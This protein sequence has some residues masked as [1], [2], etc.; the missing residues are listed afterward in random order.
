MRIRPIGVD[1]RRWGGKF[2]CEPASKGPGEKVKEADK[3]SLKEETTS[4]KEETT[5]HLL[6]LA[7][8]LPLPLGAVQDDQ[9][10]TDR[11]QGSSL[12]VITSQLL[13]HLCTISLPS[14]AQVGSAS[15]YLFRIIE[16]PPQITFDVIVAE[17]S[18]LEIVNRSRASL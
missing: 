17:I 13:G 12:R 14:L 9:P 2:S 4:S 18:N 10:I 5:S 1:E 8:S 6:L 16:V 15:K 11:S 3:E 7:P